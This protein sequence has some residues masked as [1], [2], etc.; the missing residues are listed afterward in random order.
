MDLAP[1]HHGPPAGRDRCRRFTQELACGASVCKYF[2]DARPSVSVDFPAPDR[3]LGRLRR[4]LPFNGKIVGT[5]P[6]PGQPRIHV[7]GRLSD[8][9]GAVR[10]SLW[11]DAVVGSVLCVSF[12]YNAY[13]AVVCFGCEFVEVRTCAIAFLDTVGQV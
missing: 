7:C 11:M 9:V 12:E 13:D 8:G 1:Q 4:E 5:D 10:V 2:E 3:V 6:G